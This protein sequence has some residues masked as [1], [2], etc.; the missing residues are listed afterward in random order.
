MC[1]GVETFPADLVL[2]VSSSDD[3]LEVVETAQLDGESTLKVKVVMQQLL[4][5]FASR[6]WC[7]TVWSAMRRTIGC[8]SSRDCCQLEGA[9]DGYLVELALG[10]LVT[11]S[12]MDCPR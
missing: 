8:T 7:V 12:G 2:L 3:G 5:M 6:C 9:V 11:L 10:S 1:A 4:E